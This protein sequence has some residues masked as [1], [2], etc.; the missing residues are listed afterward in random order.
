MK[1]QEIFQIWIILYKLGLVCQSLSYEAEICI[2][3]SLYQD[4]KN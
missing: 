1:K 2:I 3:S 4:K